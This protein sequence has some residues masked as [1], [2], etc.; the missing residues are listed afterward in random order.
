ME[1]I[2]HSRAI[3][4]RVPSVSRGPTDSLYEHHLTPFTSFLGSALFWVF[5]GGILA[6]ILHAI[7]IRQLGQGWLLAK[8]LFL[9]VYFLAALFYSFHVE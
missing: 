5:W 4:E 7:Y 3:A 1:A 2:Y 9:P 6:F 8:L